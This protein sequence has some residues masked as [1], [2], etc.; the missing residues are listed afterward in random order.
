MNMTQHGPNHQHGI[1]IDVENETTSRRPWEPLPSL[2]PGEARAVQ[3]HDRSTLEH[4]RTSGHGRSAEGTEG[5]GW[6]DGPTAE[7]SIQLVDLV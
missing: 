6:N 1:R 2:P 4:G 3:G 7:R 5:A